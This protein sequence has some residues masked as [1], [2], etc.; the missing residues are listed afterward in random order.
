[1]IMD[2]ISFLPRYQFVHKPLLLLTRTTQKFNR[3]SM[4]LKDIVYQS[5]GSDSNAIESFIKEVCINGNDTKKI[6]REEFFHEHLDYLHHNRMLASD[7]ILH[8]MI[9]EL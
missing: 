4:L 7:F 5:E 2:C 3:L 6:E 1:M 8:N 9:S